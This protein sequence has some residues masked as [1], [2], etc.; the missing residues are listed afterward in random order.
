MDPSQPIKHLS[1]DP[2]T[3]SQW[4]KPSSL[5]PLLRVHAYREVSSAA[6]VEHSPATSDSAYPAAST[7]WRSRPAK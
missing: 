2:E 6:V 7:P 3:L 4:R 1:A 5:G